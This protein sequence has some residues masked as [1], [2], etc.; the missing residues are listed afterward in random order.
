MSGSSCVPSSS[1]TSQTHYNQMSS[2]EEGREPNPNDTRLTESNH[3][4]LPRTS[5][6]SSPTTAK[7]LKTCTIQEDPNQNNNS[8]GSLTSA[9]NV[10]QEVLYECLLESVVLKSYTMV[11]I[12][13]SCHVYHAAP[14]LD[15][16][17]RLS[18][19]DVTS[20]QPSSFL[21]ITRHSSCLV[22]PTPP[23]PSLDL[24]KNIVFYI[25]SNPRPIQGIF[26]GVR[27][28]CLFN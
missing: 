17:S 18:P 6:S 26:D 24:L 20:E 11:A 12:H 13:V 23:T 21:Y 16:D 1:C 3:K 2:Q 19:G 5:S 14:C 27:L 25:D 22:L 28:L 10:S 9:N 8:N 15:V 4:T 7:R